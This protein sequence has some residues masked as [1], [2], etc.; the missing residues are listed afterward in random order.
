ML[1]H[2][3]Y[4]E[5]GIFKSIYQSLKRYR[6]QNTFIARVGKTSR[7]HNIHGKKILQSYKSNS[8]SKNHPYSLITRVIFSIALTRAFRPTELHTLKM[9]QVNFVKIDGNKVL[10]I[11]GRIGKS[12]SESRNWRKGFYDATHK[13]KDN[14]FWRH[15]RCG[16]QICVFDGV[17]TYYKIVSQFH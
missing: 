16:K 1:R 11:V 12:D 2:Q 13:P 4:F 7:G 10:Q 8:L 14:I 5:E 6:R 15:E 3:Q 17:E 9:N